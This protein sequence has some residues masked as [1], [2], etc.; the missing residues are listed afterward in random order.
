MG[1]L[2]SNVGRGP[3]VV[4]MTRVDISEFSAMLSLQQVSPRATVAVT[5][6]EAG[7]EHSWRDAL[8]VEVKPVAALQSG[9]HELIVSDMRPNSYIEPWGHLK[10]G[11]S[12]TRFHPDPQPVIASFAFGFKSGS[13][14]V[15]YVQVSEPVFTAESNVAGSFA[16]E[17]VATGKRCVYFPEVVEAVT[18]LQFRCEGFSSKHPIHAEFRSGM[19]SAKGGLVTMVDGSLTTSFDQVLDDMGSASVDY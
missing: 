11:R 10:D 3:Y 15:A 18:T 17:Q 1:D 6:A 16:F 14:A 5:V 9:W 2:S 13:Q 4:C 7:P 8:C 12:I 19:R